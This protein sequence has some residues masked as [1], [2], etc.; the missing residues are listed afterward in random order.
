MITDWWGPAAPRAVLVGLM[1]LFVGV[2]TPVAFAQESKAGWIPPSPADL[3]TKFDWVQLPSG[4]WLGGELVALY[5]GTLEFDSDEMGLTKIDWEDVREL[6]TV[7]VLNVRPVSGASAVG[8]VVMNKGKMTVLGDQTTVFTQGEI[9]TLTAGIPKERNY[10]SGEASGNFNIE[11][12]N[13]DKQDFNVNVLAQRRTAEQRFTG[14]YIGNYDKTDGEETKNNHRVTGDWDRFIT[15][16]FFW[17]PIFAEYYRD[18]FQNIEH[19]ITLGPGVGY[20]VIDTAKTSWRVSGGPAYTQTWFDEVAAGE[21]DNSSSAALVGKTRFDH[22]LTD[23]IDL[24]YDYRFLVASQDTGG[25]SHRMEVGVAF[26]I[27][28]DLDLRASYIWDYVSDPVENSEGATP[29]NTDTQ[30]LLGVGYSF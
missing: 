7:Q 17:K 16:R 10:W 28:G 6:R 23:D 29:E 13:T 22:E 3:P 21:D 27:T 26:D 14:E 2:V 1:A 25:Y 8:R 9:L 24:W 15:D 19:R 12:G 11:S 30:L 4:E 20:Q 5:D 18:K